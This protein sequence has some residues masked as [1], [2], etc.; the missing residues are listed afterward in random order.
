MIT[1][2]EVAELYEQRAVYAHKYQTTKDVRERIIAHQVM[3][4]LDERIAAA[5]V[6]EMRESCSASTAETHRITTR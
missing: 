3:G 4:W 1:T 5:R 6:R 2:S